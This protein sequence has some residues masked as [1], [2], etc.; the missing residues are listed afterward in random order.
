MD[1]LSIILAV[2]MGASALM[3]GDD[4]QKQTTKVDK[5]GYQSP[6]LG[7]LDAQGA[8]MLS[9]LMGVYGKAGLPSGSRGFA[10][11][12]LYGDGGIL[13]ALG[14]A[15]PGII[16]NVNNPAPVASSNPLTNPASMKTALDERRKKRADAKKKGSEATSPVYGYGKPPL[17]G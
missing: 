3:G 6:F 17:K 14:T 1:P 11:G 2:L 10:S 5:R 4:E 9:R 15:M 8:E 16:G 13:D 12:S 7:M